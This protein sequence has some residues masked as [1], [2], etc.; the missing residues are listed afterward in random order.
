[1]VTE[2]IR[3]CLLCEYLPEDIVRILV[4]TQSKSNDVPANLVLKLV[5]AFESTALLLSRRVEA[6]FAA[7]DRQM[8]GNEGEEN[9]F[10]R[11]CES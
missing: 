9:L 11:I 5:Q 4:T 2:T 8:A 6:E 3:G 7:M 1:M 10:V